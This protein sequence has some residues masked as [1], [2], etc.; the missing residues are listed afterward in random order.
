[1]TGKI[2]YFVDMLKMVMAGLGARYM[3]ND[4]RMWMM[5][6]EIVNGLS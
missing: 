5:E 2:A 3:A 6:W 4:G 1:M